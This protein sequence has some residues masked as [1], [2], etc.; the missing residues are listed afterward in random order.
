MLRA[1]IFLLQGR[2]ISRGRRNIA[3]AVGPLASLPIPFSLVTLLF[4]LDRVTEETMAARSPVLLATGAAPLALHMLRALIFLL[5]RRA[6]S[7]RRRSIACAVGPLASLPI[8]FSLGTLL[9]RLDRVTKETMAA[10]SPVL[11]ATGAAPLALHML[12]ALIFL[13]QGRAI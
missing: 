2:A 4:R 7:R 8:P 9:F 10:C 1:L 12:R 13:L 11:H 6:I 5:Q 3:C